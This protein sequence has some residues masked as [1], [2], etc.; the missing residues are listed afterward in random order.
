MALDVT[1]DP[2]EARAALAAV[3]PRLTGLLRTST[4]PGAHAVGV[5]NVAD[6]GVHLGNAWDILPALARQDRP[7]LIEDVWQLGDVT[8]ALTSAATDHDLNAIA[9]RIDAAAASFLA[10]AAE[11]DGQAR[12]WLVKGV[13]VPMTTFVC[14]LVNESL[15]HGH[16]IARAQGR[17]WR[18]DPA[19]AAL[20]LKGFLFPVLASLPPTA[21][22][23]PERVAGLTLAYRLHI[24]PGVTVDLLFEDGTARF[25]APA[26]RRID[27]HIGANAASLFLVIWGRQSQWRATFT[28]GIISWGRKPWAGPRLR[29]LMR[30][31]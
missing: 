30:N 25:E 18:I 10:L 11:P 13:E 7:P 31:P 9:D 23:V 14:H 22:V 21:M 27:C 4:R 8:T 26:R 2:A 12:P 19:H 29:T 3:V 5:W 6:V 15:V 24:R 16:D 1:A 17:P 28:G 20:V